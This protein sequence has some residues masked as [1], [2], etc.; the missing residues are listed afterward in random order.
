MKLTRKS[1]ITLPLWLVMF[2]VVGELSLVHLGAAWAAQIIEV[3][4]G[5]PLNKGAWIINGTGP[6]GAVVVSP[7]SGASFG[8]DE[9]KEPGIPGT[10]TLAASTS[11]SICGLTSSRMFRISCSVA[12]AWRAGVAT[13]V[14]LTT[15]NQIAAATVEDVTLSVTSTCISFISGSAGTCYAA[16]RIP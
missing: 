11:G 2:L 7:A 15:D 6:S 9:T 4:Q 8:S 14:A 13:P 1:S 3:Q 16:L 5:A 10:V 12:A